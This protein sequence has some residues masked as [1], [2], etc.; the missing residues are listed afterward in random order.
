VLLESEREH[1]VPVVVDI[2]CNSVAEVGAPLDEI[3]EKKAP[4]NP[5]IS[6]LKMCGL[7]VYTLAISSTKSSELAEHNT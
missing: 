7:N 5:Y 6:Y 2:S 1:V 4:I 3:K